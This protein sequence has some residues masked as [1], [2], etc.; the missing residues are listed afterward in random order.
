MV[1]P[2]RIGE[3]LVGPGQ[4]C[5]IIAEAG[6]NHNGDVALAKKL[7][8]AAAA[9]HADAVKF[10]T[11]IS[12]KVVSAASPKAAYQ[13]ST[14]DPAES[15]LEMER[16]LELP[17]DAFRELEAHARKAG[18]TFLSTPFD[19]ESAD[20]LASMDVPAIKVPSGEITNFPLLEHIARKGKPLIVSTGMADLAEVAAALEVLHAAGAKDI[21]L[22]QCVSS[23]P[24]R[25]ASANL[26]AMATMQQRFDVPV[27]FSDHTLGTEVALAAAALDACIIEKHFTLD[28]S[29]PGPDHQSS[30]EP[31]EFAAMIQGIRMV[32]SSLG[33]GI[34]RPAEEEANTRMVARRSIVATRDLAAGTPLVA[35]AVAILRPGTGMPPASLPKILGRR[36]RVAVPAGTPL[37]ADMLE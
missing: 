19:A 25:A 37:T 35:D 14:T 26:R 1:K 13:L 11:W 27:G 21:V 7:V 36:L 23:Y 15:Q 30:L 29:L 2:V 6:V 28:R 34:K 18:I 8:D 5:L 16:R 3:R 20:L 10:Q 32:E 4:P 31:A 17:F 24:A 22:L 12:E 33:D 9:I